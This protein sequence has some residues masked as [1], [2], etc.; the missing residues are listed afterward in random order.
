MFGGLKRKYNNF[1][2]WYRIVVKSKRYYKLPLRKRIWANLHGFSSDECVIFNLNRNN[3]K[4]YISE[5]ER[6]K[7]RNINGDYRV[8]MDD[9]ILF[10]KL[11]S[12]DIKIPKNYAMVLYKSVYS[13]CQL[14]L[15]NHNII[16]FIKEKKKIMLKLNGSGGGEGIH[17]ISYEADAFYIDERPIDVN[18]LH[19]Y[20]INSHNSIFS[21]YIYQGEW[22]NSLFDRTVNTTRVVVARKKGDD[23]YRVLG[24]VQRIGRETSVPVDNANAGGL[25]AE[26]DL[27]TGILNN[28][29]S[30]VNKDGSLMTFYDTHPDTG[31][32][33][34]GKQIPNWDNIKN[35]LVKLAYKYPYVNF[36]AWDIVILD[37]GIC[38][39][40]VNASSGLKIFQLHKGIRNTEFGDFYK[41]YGIIK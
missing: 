5:L 33:I 3:Y 19:N 25:T 39:L 29:A 41:S 18:A 11:F 6:M 40:E 17:V 13:L 37:D 14:D 21:E 38:A 26:I 9:K 36:F 1:K 30:R 15:N 8:V 35:Y 22:G 12:K 10:E 16:E 7:S 24:A 34:K 31:E 20:I 2:L 28:A 27:K 32:I 23:E 4:E